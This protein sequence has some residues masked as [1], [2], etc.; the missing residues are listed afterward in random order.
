MAT[1]FK[2]KGGLTYHIE[3][4]DTRGELRRVKGFK[5]KA[6][7]KELAA[8]IE[9]AIAIRQ[10]GGIL[11][12]EMLQWLEGL[13]PDLRDKL[14]EWNVIDPQRAAAGKAILEHVE[15]WR[16]ALLAKGN[17]P[18]YAKENAVKI[19]RL[20]FECKWRSL[21]DID[22]A[23][24]LQWSAN[25]RNQ[26]KIGVQTA[27]HYLRALR[28]FCNWLAENRFV[29]ES[30]I[31]FV[32]GMNPRIDRR[33]IRRALT[34]DEVGRLLIAT[35]GGKRHHGLTGQQRA[36][37]YRLA[38]ESG[39]RWSEIHSLIRSSFDFDSETPTVTIAP[40][41]E[42]AGRG[43]TLPLRPELA[44]DLKAYL[45]LSFPTA[46]AFPM[47]ADKGAEMI[48]ADLRA[49]G[50]PERDESGR[51][52]DFHALR[53]TFGSLLNLA[54][55]P[56][57]TAQDLMRHSDPKLTANFYTLTTTQ[58]R[59]KALGRLPDFHEKAKPTENTFAAIG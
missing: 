46:R 26:G 24:F 30:P 47:W 32:R 31:R 56:L 6:A 40:E 9:R 2:R 20:A 27:N 44:A 4:K 29:S 7:S 1:T 41:N 49:A 55:V 3:F 33:H 50:I 17:S 58:D 53:T 36:L 34:A 21:S 10:G 8:R 18:K 14:A 5:D 35:K 22:G 38:V 48:Q 13:R 25:S 45:A 19:I 12:G 57:K 52:V 59:A 15:N 42:K 28:T 39:L 51:V 43:D 54:G 23:A 11:A 37:V 16:R